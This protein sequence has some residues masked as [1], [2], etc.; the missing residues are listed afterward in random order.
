MIGDYEI[1]EYKNPFYPERDYYCA[2]IEDGTTYHHSEF[3]KIVEWLLHYIRNKE[4]Y[5]TNKV[6]SDRVCEEFMNNV[7][8]KD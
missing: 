7:K 4:A 6:L 2:T 5:N 8:Y 1:V 3:E